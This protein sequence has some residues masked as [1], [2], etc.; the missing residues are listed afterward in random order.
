MVQG[1]LRESWSSRR[2]KSFRRLSQREPWAE[3]SHPLMGSWTKSCTDNS[4][5]HILR[6]FA[7]CLFLYL[8]ILSPP[9]PFPFP[10]TS[11]CFLRAPIISRKLCVPGSPIHLVSR[12]RKPDFE[13]M[14]I[15]EFLDKM[16]RDRKWQKREHRNLKAPT[17]DQSY[18]LCLVFIQPLWPSSKSKR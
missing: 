2:K 4:S 14:L 10:P 3:N 5:F 1:K 16:W 11:L 12:R 6:P 7:L 8:L 13:W 18:Y 15:K 9:F 17:L